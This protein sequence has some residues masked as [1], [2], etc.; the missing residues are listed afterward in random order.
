[1]PEL[2]LPYRS[3]VPEGATR[4]PAI[5]MVHGWL[6][7]ETVM[8]VFEHAL[9]RQAAL[10]SPRG[11]FIADGG[12]GWYSESQDQESFTQGVSALR[13]FITRLTD[14]HSI[15]PTRIVL[16]G[17]SQGAA[18]S[19][20]LTLTAPEQV[21]GLAMLAGFLPTLA[22]PMLEPGKLAGKP[23]FIAHGAEDETVPIERA[24]RAR[25]ALLRAGADVTYGE[26]A[27]G[28]KMSSQGLRDLKQWLAK[29]LG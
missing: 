14:T 23:V 20:A 16:M 15:D 2:N 24:R 7:D 9:P 27:V 26:Y 4:P 3:R 6:G 5:V 17:F 1:M 10:F 22:R 25:E 11:P 29:V 18:I 28:H 8:W 13:E 19:S 21:T 12:F